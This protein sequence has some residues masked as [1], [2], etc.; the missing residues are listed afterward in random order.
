M[1]HREIIDEQCEC[2]HLMSNHHDKFGGLVK[3]HGACMECEC[4]QFTWEMFIYK[5]KNGSV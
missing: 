4:E 1:E 5:N 2:G 3:G